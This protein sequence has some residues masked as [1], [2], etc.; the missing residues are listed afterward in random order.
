MTNNTLNSTQQCLL[1]PQPGL[2]P[3]CSHM[4]P[5]WT[6]RL[7]LMF[8]NISVTQSQNIILQSPEY[9]N[10]ITELNSFHWSS[11][12]I[13]EVMALHPSLNKSNHWILSVNYNNWSDSYNIEYKERKRRGGG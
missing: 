7:V 13:L 9:Y 12:K 1:L 10:V 11:E 6:Q 5:M 4:A 8:A 3:G 2:G